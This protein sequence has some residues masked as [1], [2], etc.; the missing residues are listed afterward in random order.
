MRRTESRP[1]A[2]GEIFQETRPP[3][4]AGML[5]EGRNGPSASCDDGCC[6]HPQCVVGRTLVSCASIAFPIHCTGSDNRALVLSVPARH[7][8]VFVFLPGCISLQRV[9]TPT[10]T[11]GVGKWQNNQR[12]KGSS[13]PSRRVL[14]PSL[15]IERGGDCLGRR[16][17]GMMSL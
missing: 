10:W 17:Q 1:V 12:I 14:Y 13:P 16:T 15:W 7:Q 6:H 8:C 11:L 3:A 2:A 9:K 5:K 4:V